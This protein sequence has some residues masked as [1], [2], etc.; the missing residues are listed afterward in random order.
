MPLPT[1]KS[2][3]ALPYQPEQSL[4]NSTRFDLLQSRPPTAAMLDAEF[5]ALTDD[6]NMLA[7]AINDVQVGNIPGA[8]NPLNAN[9]LL[10]TDGN[11]NISWTLVSN[12]EL[13]ANAVTTVKIQDGAVT[14]GKIGNGAITAL[15]LA[16]N[17]ISTHNIVDSSLTTVKLEDGAVTTEKIADVNVTT[18]KLEDGAVTTEK[19]FNGAV[20]TDKIPDGAVTAEKIGLAAVDTTKI[21]SGNNLAETVLTADGAGAVSFLPNRGLVLQIVSYENIKVSKGEYNAGAMP[22]TPIS[23]A[24][25]PFLLKITPRKTNSK[26]VLFYSLNM[27]VGQNQYGSITLCKNNQ[28]FKVGTNLPGGYTGVTHSIYSAI[29]RATASGQNGTYNFSNLFVD[30]GTQGIEIS[31]E[32]KKAAP[33]TNLNSGYAAGYGGVSTM[34]A[35]E[36]DL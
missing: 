2:R 20:T 12:V 4:P 19:I 32:L 26:I 30:T 14:G 31:Y 25:E 15:K 6:V 11:S 29:G 9:K 27:G 28:P 33:Y 13:E 18:A 3:P 1:N 21:S 24:A 8:G 16:N 17:S 35:F 34:H 10:K 23:F 7:Q 36:I 22:E 5:N